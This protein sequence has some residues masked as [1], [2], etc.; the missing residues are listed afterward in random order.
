MFANIIP[1]KVL[2]SY[3]GENTS[4]FDTFCHI[5]KY[6]YKLALYLAMY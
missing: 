5:L 6:G 3:L 4:F 1:V 2:E